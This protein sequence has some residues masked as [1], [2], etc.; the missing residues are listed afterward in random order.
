VVPFDDKT[1]VTYTN[2]VYETRMDGARLRKIAYLPN[3]AAGPRI[4]RSRA[5]TR[6]AAQT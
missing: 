6:S 2:G 5:W 1:Y 3:T 4:A